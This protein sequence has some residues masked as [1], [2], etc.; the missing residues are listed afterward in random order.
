MAPFISPR[1]AS[2]DFVAARDA[3]DREPPGSERLTAR[4]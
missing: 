1:K 3:D 2:F 4:L